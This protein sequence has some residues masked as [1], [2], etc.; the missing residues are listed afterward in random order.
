ML[1]LIE[2]AV[3]VLPDNIDQI[4]VSFSGSL[5]AGEITAV[6]MAI[7]SDTVTD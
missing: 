1:E 7:A 4:N 5:D 6:P 2:N 3:P